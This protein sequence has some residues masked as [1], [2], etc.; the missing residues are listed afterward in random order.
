MLTP[1]QLK[2]LQKQ[3]EG[4]G[5]ALPRLFSA[6]A[7]S[8]RW[9]IFQI[10]LENH[11]ICVTEIAGVLDISVPAASQQLKVMEMSGLITRERAGQR[12]CYRVKDED[13]MVQSLTR[14]VQKAGTSV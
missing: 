2:R 10:L 4:K 7:D 14:L 13:Q 6:L 11:D 9:K 12:I 5:A 3:F 8:S 1:T